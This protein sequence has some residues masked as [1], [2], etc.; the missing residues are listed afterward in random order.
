MSVEELAGFSIGIIVGIVI[1]WLINAISKSMA[2]KKNG[3]KTDTSGLP[4]EYDERQIL[5]RGKAYKY[6]FY[7]MMISILLNG[8]IVA[9]VQDWCT[10]LV[11]VMVCISVSVVV[12]VGICI[13]EDAYFRLSDK[14]KASIVTLIVTG[15]LNVIGFIDAYKQNT[16]FDENGKFDNVN[17]IGAILLFVLVL[18]LLIKVRIRE[19]ENLDYEEP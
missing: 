10:I 15:L 11:F 4:M 14:P 5:A 18:M 3:N 13:F 19:K 9:C 17:I 12:F 6:G 7:T 2:G 16:L 8:M 1:V